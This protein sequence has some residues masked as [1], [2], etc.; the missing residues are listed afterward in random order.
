MSSKSFHEQYLSGKT[1]IENPIQLG[2]AFSCAFIVCAIVEKLYA[3]ANDVSSTFFKV[4]FPAVSEEV[5]VLGTLSLCLTFGS[6]LVPNLGAHE[7][8]AV[9][10]DWAQACLLFM[11]VMFVVVVTTIAVIWNKTI[12]RFEKYETQRLGTR[13]IEVDDKE[14]LFTLAINKFKMSMRAFG[15]PKPVYFSRYLRPIGEKNVVLITN[16]TWKAWLAL[17]GM[18]VLNALRAKTVDVIVGGDGVL[19][20]AS[21]I[22]VC[23]YG[24]LFLYMW[25][26]RRLTQRCQQFLQIGAAE[27]AAVAASMDPNFSALAAV[28]LVADG[29]S[30][31]EA[32]HTVAASRMDLEDPT[33]FLIWQSHA[34]TIT[35]V[36]ISFFFLVWFG[37]VFFLSMMYRIFTFN[38][39]LALFLFVLAV[40]P[41]IIYCMMCPWTFVIIAMLSSIGTCLDQAHIRRCQRERALEMTKFLHG[42]DGSKRASAGAAGGGAAGGAAAGEH[43]DRGTGGGADGRE[44]SA[45]KAHNSRPVAFRHVSRRPIEFNDEEMSRLVV[46]AQ[47]AALRQQRQPE[48]SWM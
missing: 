42:E 7:E 47:T 19:N 41:L 38:V 27:A 10:C 9:M 1:V 35:I 16:L 12:N 2:A 23:G 24:P 33:A 31:E 4:L 17:S 45:E 40:A 32:A 39:G 13:G 25:V 3:T 28:G 15:Y 22:A 34:T 44:G 21:F 20:V 48:A 26:Q 46:E 37:S 14:Q 18:V 6:S 11:A 8:W 36:Q 43:G 29:R 30:A 5:L